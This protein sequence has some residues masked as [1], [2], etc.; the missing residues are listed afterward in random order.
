MKIFYIRRNEEIADGTFGQFLTETK[1]PLFLTVEPNKPDRMSKGEYRC[2]R[3]YYHKGGYETF[4][5][6]VPGHDRVLFHKGNTEDDTK[7]CVIVGE[8]FDSMKGKTAILRSW[9]AFN[10]FMSLLAGVDE[11]K[12][13]IQ[14]VP[15][16]ES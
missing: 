7:M 3:D 5:I 12:L 4:M 6:I 10:E 9:A 15:Y 8:Q 13:V 16:W 1:Q 2:V 14:E 11:F